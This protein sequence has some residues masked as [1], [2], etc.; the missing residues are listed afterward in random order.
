MIVYVP[1][2]PPP[3]EE[4][5]DRPKRIPPNALTSIPLEGAGTVEAMQFCTT[6]PFL[7]FGTVA[8]QVGVFDTSCMRM[9]QLWTYSDPSTGTDEGFGIT[10]LRWSRANPLTFFTATLAATVLNCAYHRLLL[11]NFAAVPAASAAATLDQ[12]SLDGQDHD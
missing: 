9:R 3:L 1:C 7:A 10:A 12:S 11:A 4:I 6:H 5:D 8:G 2:R